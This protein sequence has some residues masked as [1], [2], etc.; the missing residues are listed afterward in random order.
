MQFYILSCSVLSRKPTGH[1]CPAKFR[2]PSALYLQQ[3][4][5]VSSFG[6]PVGT[7]V[8]KQ[9]NVLMLLQPLS[10]RP[11]PAST[12]RHSISLYNGCNHL[13]VLVFLLSCLAILPECCSKVHHCKTVLAK[14]IGRFPKPFITQMTFISFA[15]SDL[16]DSYQ[17]SSTG[18]YCTYR[19]SKNV[20]EPRKTPVETLS[21]VAL[22][23]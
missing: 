18:E 17:Y 5:A 14:N 8:Y 22:V 23:D 4:K 7:W 3:I 6:A 11:H 1:I 13:V 10:G 15:C 2:S 12:K 20:D 9:V 19:P 16:C 21:V